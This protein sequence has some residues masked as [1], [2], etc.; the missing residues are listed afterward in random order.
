[1]AMLV[2]PTM[3]I[4]GLLSDQLGLTHMRGEEMKMIAKAKQSNAEKN[5]NQN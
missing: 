2:W 4:L 5:K 3:S 1:M